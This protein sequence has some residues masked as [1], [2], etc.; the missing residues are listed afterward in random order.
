MNEKTLKALKGSIRKWE[1]IVAGKGVDKGHGNCPLCKAFYNRRTAVYPWR[2]PVAKDTGRDC[3]SDT[4]YSDW[5]YYAEER[6][7][8]RDVDG[9][10]CVMVFDERSKELAVKELEYLKSL[11]PEGLARMGKSR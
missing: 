3:C 11:L 7:E 9:D 5:Q 1:G 6:D 10:F 8:D 4:P 2:C